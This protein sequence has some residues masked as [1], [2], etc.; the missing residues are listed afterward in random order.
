MT[1]GL[2]LHSWS[3]VHS[4]PHPV[5]V[6]GLAINPGRQLQMAFPVG[7]TV[8]VVPGPQGEGWQGLLGIL[9]VRL[10]KT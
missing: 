6:S 8:Q 1:F 7:L 5:I 4:G 9:V 3:T 2:Y 10:I